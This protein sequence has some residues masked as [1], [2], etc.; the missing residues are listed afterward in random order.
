MLRIELNVVARSWHLAGDVA[1][2]VRLLK[3]AAQ[4]RSLWFI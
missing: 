2:V 4:I 1:E 3:L